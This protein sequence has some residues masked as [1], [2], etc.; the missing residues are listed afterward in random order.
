M[1]RPVLSVA[2]RL[3]DEAQRAKRNGAHGF[4]TMEGGTKNCKRSERMRM[5]SA[6]PY[7]MTYSLR[8]HPTRRTARFV[9]FPFAVLFIGLLVP[10]CWCPCRKSGNK[11]T[12]EHVWLG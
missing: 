8:S 11:L 6:Y 7:S 12:S 4:P 5:P 1:N 2:Q 3:K 10:T 9:R